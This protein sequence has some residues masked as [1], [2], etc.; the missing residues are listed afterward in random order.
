MPTKSANIKS[1][2]VTALPRNP[3]EH[4]IDIEEQIYVMFPFEQPVV[5]RAE[6]DRAP[7]LRLPFQPQTDRT[8]PVVG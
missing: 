3:F 8:V 1:L 2:F 6:S 5:M 4:D 7:G